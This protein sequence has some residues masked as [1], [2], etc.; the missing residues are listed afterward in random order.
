M[1]IGGTVAGTTLGL[2]VAGIAVSAGLA[3]N[4]PHVPPLRCD[5]AAECKVTA[6]HLHADL[7][8]LRTNLTHL[9]SAGTGRGRQ[10][11]GLQERIR[12][13]ETSLTGTR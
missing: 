4:D 2:A 10:L 3:A 5:T 11:E 6:K 7:V 12:L 13:L 1:G 8:R 9:E